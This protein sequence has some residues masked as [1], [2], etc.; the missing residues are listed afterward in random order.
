MS[1]NFVSHLKDK[2]IAL[3]FRPIR[4]SYLYIYRSTTTKPFSENK[5]FLFIIGPRQGNLV[6]IAYASSEGSG[7]SHRFAVGLVVL[8]GNIALLPHL[9]D[10]CAPVE[11]NILKGR[12]DKTHQSVLTSGS[13]NHDIGTNK[14]II[15]AVLK[16]KD[17]HRFDWA[18]V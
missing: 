9:I 13:P 6:L 12:K 15:Q 18:K 7:C 4:F 8:Q 17:T 2:S 3:Y 5:P 11:W 16:I 10:L 14:A 1:V